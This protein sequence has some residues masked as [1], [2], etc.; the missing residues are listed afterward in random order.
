MAGPD[1]P[2]NLDWTLSG[3]SAREEQR[4]IE[5]IIQT[6]GQERA[7]EHETFLYNAQMKAEIFPPEDQVEDVTLE[8][9]PPKYQ[10]EQVDLMCSKCSSAMHLIH[11]RNG[12]FYGCV[13]FPKCKN[14]YDSTAKGAPKGDVPRQPK[15]QWQRL[16]EDD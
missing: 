12:P 2:D 9:E 4:K 8:V 6:L 11:G 1:V 5:R 7:R 15:T 14:S 16:M 10:D 3:N 13:T